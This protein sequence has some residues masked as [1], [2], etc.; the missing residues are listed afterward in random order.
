MGLMETLFEGDIYDGFPASDFELDFTGFNLPWKALSLI[1]T[2]RPSRII[3]VGTWKGN[4]AFWMADR[5]KG[6]GVEFE[7]VC[8]DTWLGSAEMWTV[9]KREEIPERRK[10]LGLYHGYPTLYFQFLANVIKLGYQRQIVPMPMPSSIAHDILAHL[11]YTAQFIYVDGSHAYQD[12]A[13][14]VRNYW[15]LLEP[16]GI[17]VGDDYHSTVKVAFD[18]F[19]ERIGAPLHVVEG[20]YSCWLQKS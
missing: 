5:L 4:S 14:D 13:Q 6:M 12:A 19:A 11:G 8:V 9:A 10:G 20:E 1:D 15:K 3:E 2:V 17:M 16:G 18:R 7:L